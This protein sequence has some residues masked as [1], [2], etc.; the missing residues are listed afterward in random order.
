MVLAQRLFVEITL[1]CITVINTSTHWSR[2]YANTTAK[3]TCKTPPERK[4]YS[5]TVTWWGGRLE[6]SDRKSGDTLVCDW[7]PEGGVCE[8]ERVGA[9]RVRAFVFQL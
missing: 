9:L 8:N 7:G 1:G 6:R 2:N 5:T 3:S 4:D